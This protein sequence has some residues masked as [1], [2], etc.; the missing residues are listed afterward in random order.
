MAQSWLWFSQ[1]AVKSPLSFKKIF[2]LEMVRNISLGG[3]GKLNALFSRK[4]AQKTRPCP[5]HQEY[6]RRCRVI[7]QQASDIT[8]VWKQVQ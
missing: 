5:Q 8:A 7:Y 6:A 1:I 3:T 4:Y 2:S